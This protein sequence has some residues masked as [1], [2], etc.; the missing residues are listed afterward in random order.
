[1]I[2]REGISVGEGADELGI[3]PQHLSTCRSDILHHEEVEQAE[4]K[5]GGQAEAPWSSTQNSP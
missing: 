2:I 1:M 3:L 5:L 4:K